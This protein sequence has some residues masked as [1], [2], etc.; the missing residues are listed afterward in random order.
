MLSRGATVFKIPLNGCGEISVDRLK[1]VAIETRDYLSLSINHRLSRQPTSLKPTPSFSTSN[2]VTLGSVTS[3]KPAICAKANL[4]ST[5]MTRSGRRIQFP[6][7]SSL[8]T[9]LSSF[10]DS[11]DVESRRRVMSQPK[12]PSRITR[13]LSILPHGRDRLPTEM[14]HRAASC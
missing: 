3:P 2:P 5:Q 13:Q 14:S 11:A 10:V 1:T 7:R 8:L 9:P 6:G 12:I 4:A